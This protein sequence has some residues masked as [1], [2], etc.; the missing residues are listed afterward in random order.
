MFIIHRK[1]YGS[2]R[3]LAALDLYENG[4]VPVLCII[5]ASYIFCLSELHSLLALFTSYISKMDTTFPEFRISASCILFLIH[6]ITW[7]FVDIAPLHI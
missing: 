2:I 4:S 5:S 6:T 1:T 7:Y 3:P